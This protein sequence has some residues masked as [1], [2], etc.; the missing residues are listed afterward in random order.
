[1]TARYLIRFDDICPTMN[2]GIWSKVEQVLVE[3]ET[4]PILAVIPDN[5]DKNLR[6][7]DSDCSFW[8]KV[9]SWQQKGWTIGLHGYQHKYVKKDCGIIRLNTR[10][11][12]AGLPFEEQERKINRAVAIFRDKGVHPDLWIAPA[13]SFDRITIAVLKKCDITIISDGYY[14]FPHAGAD[15]VFWLPQQL[16]RFRWLPFGVWTVCCHHNAWSERDIVRFQSDVLQY[17]N[18]ITDVPE[19]ARI[20]QRRRPTWPDQLFSSLFLFSVRTKRFIS[21]RG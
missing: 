8:E 12:F 1:V 5:Q 21:S 10:S 9:K 20:F 18:A 17:R 16:W 19:I 11:E 3:T 6:I 7:A 2:W 4:K 14:L 15:G 13:H